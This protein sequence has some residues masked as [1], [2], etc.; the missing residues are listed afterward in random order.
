VAGTTVSGFSPEDGLIGEPW[1]ADIKILNSLSTETPPWVTSECSPGEAGFVWINTP[2]LMKGYLGR[3]D[4]TR[5]V[6]SQGWFSTG[7][8][9][10]LDD[11]GLLYLKG[12]EREEINKGGMKVYPA[13]IDA[14]AERFEKMLDVCTFGF[15]D[16][17]FGENVGIAVVLKGQNDETI[18]NLVHWLQRHLGKH[19]MPQ[20]WYLLDEIP[21]TSRGKVNRSL[22]AQKCTPLEP[23]DTRKLF[24]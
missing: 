2:A 23:V 14:V 6:V 7:D 19:Q 17:L 11:R 20:R 16:L 3:E 21:R 18:R 10:L 13:D 22:V 24:R 8:I 9:G 12:R 4:L 1:G 5:K 15:E